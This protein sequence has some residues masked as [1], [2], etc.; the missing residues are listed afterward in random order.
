MSF[1]QTVR[2]LDCR[3]HARWSPRQVHPAHGAVPNLARVA[4][5]YRRLLFEADGAA[6]AYSPT[7]GRAADA[8]FHVRYSSIATHRQT[9][10]PAQK[11]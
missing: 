11:I 8:A 4:R 7:A 3:G 5:L 6:V 2:A 9:V 10:M 1:S